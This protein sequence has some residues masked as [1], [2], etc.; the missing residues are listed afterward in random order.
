VALNVKALQKRVQKLE[1]ELRPPPAPE[2]DVVVRPV[3][4]RG[5]S[6]APS[7]RVEDDIL[8]ISIAPPSFPGASLWQ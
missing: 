5:G 4:G 3:V 2:F 6:G 1:A 8:I 7:V